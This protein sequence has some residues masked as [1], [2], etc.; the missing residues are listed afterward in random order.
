MSRRNNFMILFFN[1]SP[2]RR[3]GNKIIAAVNGPEKQDTMEHSFSLA[4]KEINSVLKAGSLKVMGKK[5]ELKFLWEN[6][7]SFFSWPGNLVEPHLLMLVFGAW[8]I[9][10]T[11]GTLEKQLST[12]SVTKWKAWPFEWKGILSDKINKSLKSIHFSENYLFRP[13]ALYLSE[14]NCLKLSDCKFELLLRSPEILF[15]DVSRQEKCEFTSMVFDCVTAY[16]YSSSTFT[17]SAQPDI[18]LRMTAS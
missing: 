3:K 2:N 18:L 6:I 10:W 17:S 7:T 5:Y 15:I 13:V 8:V 11:D 9:S 16:L 12:T 1:P 4:T 14:N